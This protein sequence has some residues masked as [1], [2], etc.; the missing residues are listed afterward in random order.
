MPDFKNLYLAAGL[1]LT[2]V[3]QP[4]YAHCNDNITSKVQQIIDLDREKY[5]I[6]GIEVSIICPGE[7]TPRDFVSGYT[8]LEQSAA[9][10]PDNLFQIGSETKSF[11]AALILLWEAE[12]K[13]SID[14]SVSEYLS[15]LPQSWQNITIRQL[16]NHTSGIYNYTDVL[17]KKVR[18]GDFD[19]NQQWTS[20]ELVNLVTEEPL[21]FEPGAGWHYS[22]TNYVL[23]G[24]IIEQVSGSELTGQLKARLIEPLQLQDTF[25]LPASYSP[26]IMERMAHGYSDRGYFP[27]EPKDITDFSHSWTNAAGGM[28]ATSHDTALWIKALAQGYILPPTQMQELMTTINATLPNKLKV[29]YGLGII[30]DDKTFG[31]EAWWHS[32]GTLGFSSLMIWL[33]SS[34]VILTVNIS[35]YAKGEDLYL[36]AQEL[37]D[38][39][40]K[41]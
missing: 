1:T 37:A 21:Y 16:L 40:H 34:D 27:D 26:Q 32:G 2:F 39:L 20:E 17:D 15:D 22:N 12:G 11:I 10:K 14:D 24:L 5:H 13:L 33:K 3:F 30:H 8:T 28:V 4:I 23:A 41:S 25:Y 35:H 7:S 6:P 36:I 19:F 29:Q 18:Q 38:A 31:E 9:L